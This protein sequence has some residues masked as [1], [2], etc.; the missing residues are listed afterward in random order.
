MTPIFRGAVVLDGPIEGVAEMCKDTPSKQVEP[1]D[2]VTLGGDTSPT[3]SQNSADIEIPKGETQMD[4]LQCCDGPM[5]D[6]KRAS[7]KKEEEA[8]IKA[9]DDLSPRRTSTDHE[10]QQNNSVMQQ[11]EYLRK[12]GEG[13]YAEVRADKDFPH[14]DETLALPK[15]TFLC[16]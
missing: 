13:S 1:E 2:V 16:V 7:P 5:L 8:L 12:I 6:K 11:Y 4:R 3:S 9:D 15:T 10:R 14:P